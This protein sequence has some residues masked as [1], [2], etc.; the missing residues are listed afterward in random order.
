MIRTFPVLIR[1]V[2]LK[3]S[4]FRLVFVNSDCYGKSNAIPALIRI[5]SVQNVWN[6]L[7]YWNGWNCTLQKA[8]LDNQVKNRV[9]GQKESLRSL[10]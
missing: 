9:E 2:R 8:A 6:D 1:F 10:L 7:N 3:S 5:P 4:S